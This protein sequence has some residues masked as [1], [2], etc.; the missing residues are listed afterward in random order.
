MGNY[1][2][3]VLMQS[4]VIWIS[5][6]LL[7]FGPPPLIWR[8]SGALCW[9][10]AV[11]CSL[12][13]RGPCHITYF[14]CIELMCFLAH[15]SDYYHRYIV[16]CLKDKSLDMEDSLNLFCIFVAVYHD[17]MYQMYR[18][19]RMYV[20]TSYKPIKLPEKSCF[21]HKNSHILGQLTLKVYCW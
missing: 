1:F 17:P 20:M 12:S 3:L 14:I 6:L 4:R 7:K 11:S 9:E 10:T 21:F 5:L 2:W 8:S 19:H 16:F 18:M 15:Q 13:F